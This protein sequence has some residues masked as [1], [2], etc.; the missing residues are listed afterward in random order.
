MARLIAEADKSILCGCIPQV[1]APPRPV[2]IYSF[3]LIPSRVPPPDR[4]IFR[5]WQ[6]RWQHALSLRYQRPCTARCTLPVLLGVSQNKIKNI[7][8]PQ[9]RSQR[10]RAASLISARG[11]RGET[12][13]KISM[14]RTQ[15]I[16][17]GFITSAEQKG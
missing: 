5:L 1:C 2:I 15:D 3:C 13:Y 14:E 9:I 17:N 4:I 11:S 6:T 7:K 10:A 16:V 8:K 12:G